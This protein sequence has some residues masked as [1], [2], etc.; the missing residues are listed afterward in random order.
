MDPELKE[1]L[2]KAKEALANSK[3]LEEAITEIKSWGADKGR[4]AEAEKAV[5][6]LREDH[7]SMMADLTKR[8]DQIRRQVLSANG[9]YRGT[10]AS[11]E[12]AREFALLMISRTSRDHSARALEIL[13]ADHKEF[14][15]RATGTPHEGEAGLVPHEHSS[16][17]QRLVEEFGLYG[18]LAFRMPMSSDTL[19]FHRRKSGLR[20]RKSKVRTTVSEQTMAWEPINLTAEDFDIL[21]SYPIYL[22]DDALVAIAEVLAQE[23]GLG[24]ATALDEDGFTGDG[25]ADFDT[26][27]GITFRLTEINGVDDGGGLVL[28][29]GAAGAG[30][31]GIVEGDIAKL[32]GQARFVRPGMG[33]LVGSNEFYWQVLAKLIMAK[34]GVTRREAEEGPRLQYFGVP[35]EVTPAMPRTAGNSQV[36]LLFG[37]VN[38]SSTIGDRKRMEIRESREVRFESKEVVV[39]ASARYAIN[40]H[41]LGDDTTPGPVVGLITP[42]AP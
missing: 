13:N 31:G 35:Y 23:I 20:A 18:R 28:A 19:T 42:A 10:F 37:D 14:M 21:V 6:Q 4:L 36:P 17:I 8:L 29:S 15:Q 32:I 1:L 11:E 30:W 2:A 9:S 26:E 22:A 33:R 39:L 5:N 41:S 40:N 27:V 34:G 24:F 3:K 38:R 16:R 25:T 12:Q 7:K